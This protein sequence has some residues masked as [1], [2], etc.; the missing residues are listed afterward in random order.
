MSVH[1]HMTFIM[2]VISFHFLR[3]LARKRLDLLNEFINY[4]KFCFSYDSNILNVFS[5]PD[6]TFL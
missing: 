2:Q 5:T 4:H 3:A 6:I 1:F